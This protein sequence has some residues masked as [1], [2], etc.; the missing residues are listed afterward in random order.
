MCAACGDLVYLRRRG[1]RIDL[2]IYQ[3]RVVD[4]LRISNH[5][6]IK[7]NPLTIGRRGDDVESIRKVCGG[8]DRRPG[9]GNSIIRV[10]LNGLGGDGG[11]SEPF[12]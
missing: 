8:A 10:S 9:S 6:G 3:G 2:D 1:R 4:G 12:L 7:L 5:S 11:D